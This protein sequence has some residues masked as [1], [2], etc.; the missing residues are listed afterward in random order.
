MQFLS[1]SDPP[2]NSLCYLANSVFNVS[3]L[4]ANYENYLGATLQFDYLTGSGYVNYTTPPII[5]IEVNNVDNLIFYFDPFA[6]PMGNVENIIQN[7][8]LNI[9]NSALINS[10]YGLTTISS[11]NDTSLNLSS[12][13]DPTTQFPFLY[14]NTFTPP[15]TLFVNPFWEASAQVVAPSS[16]RMIITLADASTEPLNIPSAPIAGH[17][18]ILT[19]IS[20][21]EPFIITGSSY[22]A[23]TGITT[24]T[25]A[26]NWALPDIPT[27][28]S[29]NSLHIQYLIL[30][31]ITFPSSNY[32]QW[33]ANLL[34]ISMEGS[35]ISSVIVSQNISN[36][37]YNIYNVKWFLCLVN[38]C[39][40]DVWLAI[41]PT[42]SALAP[43]FTVDE[44]T[45][46]FTLFTPCITTPT[47]INFAPSETAA[48]GLSVTTP[49]YIGENS[50]PAVTH[51]IFFNEPLYNLFCGINSV[52]Y[53]NKVPIFAS[54][55]DQ[56]IANANPYLFNYYMQPIN[57]SGVN[58]TGNFTFTTAE[59]SSVPM[60]SPIK[61][62]QFTSTLLPNLLTYT[63]TPVPFNNLN[64]N[65]QQNI[66]N[67]SEIS[68]QITDIQIGL[69]TGSEY[70]PQLLYVP[71]TQY[72]LITLLGS[73]T[74]NA[75]DFQISF[76][77]KYGEIIPMRLSSQC[78]A[79]LKILFQRK[80][81]NL[82]NLPPYD[83]N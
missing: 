19:N 11:I 42:Q 55:N 14:Q 75:I 56:L 43:F 47:L 76:T 17:Q 30:T 69:V 35:S 62:I 50:N 49:I 65:G 16:I 9:A 21:Y 15:S 83:T 64:H 34:S 22:S 61:S 13:N 41:E 2:S 77:N 3:S 51:T 53:G 58:K 66:G 38:K 80:R 72:R 33:T 40:R 32:N 78:T 79:N 18:I 4:P 6:W 44:G 8:R 1:F 81:M 26:N 52:Y 57:Y 27:T 5:I 39:L 24:F 48:N 7:L 45:N 70:K 63:S 73:N 37:Y 71:R 10:A 60:W 46:F 31:T 67:N 23:G 36:G 54:P 82:K 20:A 68:S 29:L 74:M 25:P 12:P 28:T 59:Y